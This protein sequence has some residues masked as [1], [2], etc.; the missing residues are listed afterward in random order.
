MRPVLVDKIASVAVQADL[1]QE[2]IAWFRKVR[3]YDDYTV[4]IPENQL[5]LAAALRLLRVPALPGPTHTGLRRQVALLPDV[6]LLVHRLRGKVD[7][8]F[9]VKLIHTFRGVGYALKVEK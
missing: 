7:K 2:I 4:D 1:G 9:P 3:R 5:L 8:D 6:S